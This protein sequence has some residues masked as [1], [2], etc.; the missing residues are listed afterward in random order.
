MNK[1]FSIFHLDGEEEE[2]NRKGEETFSKTFV[3]FFVLNSM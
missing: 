2:C 1:K 3:S